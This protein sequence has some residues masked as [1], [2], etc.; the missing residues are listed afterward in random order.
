MQ[1]KKDCHAGINQEEGKLSMIYS[2]K[3]NATREQNHQ[4]LLECYAKVKLI[5][6]KYKIMPRLLQYNNMQPPANPKNQ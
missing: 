3:D 2:H 5:L 4:A 6:Y 1:Q